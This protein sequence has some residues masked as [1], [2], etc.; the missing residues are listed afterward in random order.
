MRDSFSLQSEFVLLIICVSENI[1]I[2]PLKQFFLA[3][4]FLTKRLCQSKICLSKFYQALFCSILYID[5]FDFL[6]YSHVYNNFI[7][8]HNELSDVRV[9]LFAKNEFSSLT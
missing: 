5:Y 8:N 4:I 9:I 1:Q 6:T 3:S 7:L 2:F